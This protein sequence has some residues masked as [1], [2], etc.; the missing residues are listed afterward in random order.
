M[1]SLITKKIRFNTG[2]SIDFIN[3][4]VLV[5]A[6]NYKGA[7][8]YKNLDNYTYSSVYFPRLSLLALA[9]RIF[10]GGGI[11]SVF[12]FAIMYKLDSSDESSHLLN[13]LTSIVFAATIILPV[14]IFYGELF[15]TILGFNFADKIIQKYY[16]D[17]RWVV[18][19][20]NKSGNNI[21]F[22]AVIDEIEKVKQLEKIISDIKKNYLAEPKL[23]NEV[24]KSVPSDYLMELSKLNELYKQGVLTDVEF[25]TKKTEILNRKS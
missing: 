6:S 19:I 18:V 14:F 3:N 9:A 17:K 10:L 25:T 7:I 13:V 1:E 20:G 11:L 24:T 12:L 2:V 5:T 16:S 23:Q 15:N 22:Y 8:D 21:K 4:Q